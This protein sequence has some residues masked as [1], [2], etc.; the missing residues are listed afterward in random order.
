MF[1]KRLRSRLPSPAAMRSHPQMRHLGWFFDRPNLWH[2]NRRSV[3]GAVAVGMITGL[4]PGP[5]QML[6]AALLAI[7]L[8]V[9]VA[10]AM[11]VTLYTNPIT[12]GPLY[13]IAYEMGSLFL[14]NGTAFPAVPQWSLSNLGQW[15][16][17]MVYWAMGLGKPLGL[18]LVLLAL[19]LAA[20]GWVV[21]WFGWR[22]AV[23]VA[24]ARRCRRRALRSQARS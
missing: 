12:I 9:N 19:S 17:A 8:R 6:G 1:I 24:W 21:T 16:E 13:W 14:G 23:S 2:L 22:C 5:L 10:V 15:T 7:P 11:A 3:A 4:I 18:G 20:I